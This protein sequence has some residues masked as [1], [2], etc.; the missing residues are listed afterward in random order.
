MA[1]P[2]DPSLVSWVSDWLPGEDDNDEEEECGGSNDSYEGN[3]TYD[4]GYNNGYDDSYS[5]R[6]GNNYEY[7]YE[8][9]DW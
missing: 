7:V 4:D 9:E 8:E 6:Y 2:G 5:E 3:S 1:R